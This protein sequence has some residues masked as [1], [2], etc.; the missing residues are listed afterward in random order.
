LKNHHLAVAF[1]VT[2]RGQHRLGGVCCLPLSPNPGSR[3]WPQ[4]AI[5]HYDAVSVFHHVLHALHLQS[6]THCAKPFSTVT[7]AVFKSRLKSFLFS[8]ASLLPVL[9]NTLP[10]PSASE[11]TTLWCYTTLFIIIIIT[12]C[13]VNVCRI[14]AGVDVQ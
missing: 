7:V 13:D 5:D 14:G 11:V 6:G 4:P 2:H 12:G 3:K 8:K 10:G 9:T 1:K